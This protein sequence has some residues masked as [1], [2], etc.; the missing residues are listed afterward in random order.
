M[1]SFAA[2]VSLGTVIL[3]KNDKSL[4]IISMVLSTLFMCTLLTC[5]PWANYLIR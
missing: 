1:R 4:P 2:R 3:F 5:A